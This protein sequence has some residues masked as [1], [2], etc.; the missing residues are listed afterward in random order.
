MIR[1]KL[2]Y[3]SATR[4]STRWTAKW[5]SKDGFVVN[6]NLEDK[7]TKCN[8]GGI[9]SKIH[10]TRSIPSKYPLILSRY[11]TWY[12]TYTRT[13]RWF[14]SKLHLGADSNQSTI[15]VEY[16]SNPNILL[17]LVLRREKVAL[18]TSGESRGHYTSFL[19][20]LTANSNYAV[21]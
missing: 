4:K 20:T 8:V 13:N 11:R 5:T 15:Y 19:C 1:L 7:G 17:S 12:W 9:D 3:Q 6:Q 2:W 21:L 18:Y 14:T 10:S 16:L